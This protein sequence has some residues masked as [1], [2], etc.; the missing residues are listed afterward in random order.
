MRLEKLIRPITIRSGRHQHLRLKRLSSS[1]AGFVHSLLT[2]GLSSREFVVRVLH[3]Q[4]WGDTVSSQILREWPDAFLVWGANRWLGRSQRSCAYK[5]LASFDEFKDFLADF[6]E[7][8]MKQLQAPQ[9]AVHDIYD[10]AVIGRHMDQITGN[11]RKALAG[12]VVVDPMVAAMCAAQ[13]SFKQQLFDSVPQLP[14]L[15]RISEKYAGLAS[16]LARNAK[17]VQSMAASF[18]IKQT[19][20]LSRF[21]LAET[22]KSRAS[23]LNQFW[24]GDFSEGGNRLLP[25]TRKTWRES[26]G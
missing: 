23:I 5:S 19:T 6:S 16:E 22:A 13:G 17:G 24:R 1:D 7:R 20:G 3:H 25:F 18:Q 12:S 15:S 10:L 14:E 26:T 8:E 11:F 21:T 9:Q 4:V 2:D